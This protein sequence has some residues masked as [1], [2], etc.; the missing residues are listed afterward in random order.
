VITCWQKKAGAEL[1]PDVSTRTLTIYGAGASE[2]TLLKLAIEESLKTHEA[3]NCVTDLSKTDHT[4]LIHT[5][6]W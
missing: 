1:F 5:N 6:T 3:E 4:E 2:D